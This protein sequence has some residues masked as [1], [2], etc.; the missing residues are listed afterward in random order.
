[1][2]NVR[3]CGSAGAGFAL[4]LRGFSRFP[5]R[6]SRHSV[7]LLSQRDSS[8]PLVRARHR[9]SPNCLLW[10]PQD[11]VQTRTQHL[12]PP[13]HDTISEQRGRTVPGWNG[14]GEEAPRLPR[15][16]GTEQLGE[17]GSFL[18]SPPF[19][20]GL[21]TQFVDVSQRTRGNRSLATGKLVPFGFHAP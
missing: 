5:I 4:G 8:T 20:R 7:S 11:F 18:P 1:M 6:P 14:R 12:S 10:I 9:H 19:R 13:D 2:P 21:E 15:G 17:G 3:K 16:N